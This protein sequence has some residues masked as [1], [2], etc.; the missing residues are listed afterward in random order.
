MQFNIRCRGKILIRSVREHLLKFIKD[1]Q[2]SFSQ[3]RSRLNNLL[4][5]FE[6]NTDMTDKWNLIGVTELN[7]QEAFGKVPL[8]KLLTR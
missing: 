1:G 7:F 3:E 4:E 2:N 5:F 6:D 8:Q